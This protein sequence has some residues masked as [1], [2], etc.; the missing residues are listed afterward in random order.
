MRFENTED[1]P[2]RD[3]RTAA[4]VISAIVIFLGLCAVC[5]KSS[6]F[7]ESGKSRVVARNLDFTKLD[8]PADSS[9][10]QIISKL[11]NGWQQ[12][13]RG[14]AT[15]RLENERDTSHGEPI[16]LSIYAN[17][18][19]F[20]HWAL[21]TH[22]YKYELRERKRNGI[23]YDPYDLEAGGFQNEA[24]QPVEAFAAR[25]AVE[26]VSNTSGF[27]R[28]YE[29]VIREDKDHDPMMAQR[30]EAIRQ[31]QVPRVYKDNVGLLYV[32]HL[33]WTTKTKD[34]VDKICVAVAQS[35]GRYNVVSNNCQH[36]VRLL[37]TSIVD[38]KSEDWEWFEG[39][40]NK[41]Y[42]YVGPLTIG[43]PAGLAQLCLDRLTSMLANDEIKDPEVK[44]KII[45]HIQTLSTYVDNLKR[46]I[47]EELNR[48]VE[49]GRRDAGWNQMMGQMG[50]GGGMA[51]G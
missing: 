28:Y 27:A 18:A 17:M 43:P 49:F 2:S 9:E 6:K 1:D 50:S 8:I 25:D 39:A 35:F 51:G 23:R 3:V 34:E 7:R 13:L 48:T 19:N 37:A 16:W 22:R 20:R 14:R 44:A 29:Q 5:V 38:K 33:G 40:A 21:L 45:E 32:I 47:D 15:S 42:E 46:E 41:R 4:G 12:H 31:T 11:Q 30:A 10:E 24:D 36:F 26:D